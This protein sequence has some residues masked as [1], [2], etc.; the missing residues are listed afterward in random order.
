MSKIVIILSC[1]FHC[2][3]H[4]NRSLCHSVRST[5]ILRGQ[6][7]GIPAESQFSPKNVW[8]KTRQS[9]D[10]CSFYCTRIPEERALAKHI[11]RPLGRSSSSI[12]DEAVLVP[13][14]ELEAEWRERQI[15]SVDERADESGACRRCPACAAPRGAHC[16]RCSSTADPVRLWPTTGGGHGPAAIRTTSPRLR[17]QNRARGSRSRTERC[18]CWLLCGRPAPFARSVWVDSSPKVTDSSCRLDRRRATCVF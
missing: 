8:K 3:A 5:A 17:W 2:H 18:A 14:A 11:N 13:T 4:S 1:V 9:A 6:K 16:V 12:M 10:F 7:F 15:A